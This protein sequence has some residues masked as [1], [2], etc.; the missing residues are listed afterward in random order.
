MTKIQPTVKWEK[1]LTGSNDMYLDYLSK[2]G[3]SFLQTLAKNL[4]S[5]HKANK[6]SIVLFTFG[7]SGIV[8]K[9]KYDE[10]KLILNNLLTLCERL[11]YYEICSEIYG[12]TNSL[13]KKRNQLR[14]LKLN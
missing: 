3:N 4:I 9:A 6:P 7:D 13:H 11:E 8:S 5:A 10:Y 12:Y 1:Y 14:E 2:Y